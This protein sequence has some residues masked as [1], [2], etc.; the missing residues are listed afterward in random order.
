MNSVVFINFATAEPRPGKEEQLA[1]LMKNFRD[2][3]RPMSGNVGVYVLKEKVTGNI[4]GLSIWKDE[5]SF[6]AAMAKMTG[7]PSHSPEDVRKAPPV[8]RQFVEIH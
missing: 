2:A 5:A 6:E 4:A 7:A 3:L 1:E 8:V